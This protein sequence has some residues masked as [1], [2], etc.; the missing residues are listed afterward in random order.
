MKQELIYVVNYKNIKS[1]NMSCY[2]K[3]KFYNIKIQKEILLW[4]KLK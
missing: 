4:I 3:D 2:N 1:L